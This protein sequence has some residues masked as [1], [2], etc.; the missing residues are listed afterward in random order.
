MKYE[1]QYIINKFNLK[2]DLGKTYVFHRMSREYTLTFISIRYRLAQVKMAL[3]KEKL[4]AMF[5]INTDSDIFTDSLFYESRVIISLARFKHWTVK[6]SNA[7]CQF[8]ANIKI[9][10]CA[11]RFVTNSLHQCAT[12]HFECKKQ[13]A[14]I[15][16]VLYLGTISAIYVWC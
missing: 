2:I 4:C 12:F 11:K 9:P 8:S 13:R 1:N 7:F 14:R 10:P 16:W 6:A 5:A 3:T 15:I